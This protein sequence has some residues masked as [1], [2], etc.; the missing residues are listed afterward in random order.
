MNKYMF[1]IVLLCCGWQ[2]ICQNNK[3]MLEIRVLPIFANQMLLE[4]KWFVSPAGDSL[5][6]TKMRFYLSN[7][8]LQ[9]SNGQVINDPL[10]AHLIDVFEPATLTI[11]LPIDQ[12]TS[13]KASIH[14]LHFNLGIDS[15]TSVAG[16]LAGDLDPTKGMYWAWQS[17]Y[18][19]LKIEGIS[20]QC[21]TR[22]NIFQYHIGG[23]LAPYCALRGVDLPIEAA[24]NQVLQLQVDLAV[25][26]QKVPLNKQNSIMIP[27]KAAMLL[28]DFSTQMFSL[29]AQQK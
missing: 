23:Y 12:S 8:R 9:L 10:A 13:D 20:P 22:K 27:G 5:R 11:M 21:K 17:G 24:T 15:T 7:L 26:F 14:K 2:G 29:H 16:A 4:G 28:A 18:I 19:N 25:F 3:A 6:C 1:T